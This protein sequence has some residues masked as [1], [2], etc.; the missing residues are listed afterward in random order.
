MKNPILF[1]FFSGSGF[2]DLGF[3]LNNFNV[4]FVNEYHKP[5]LEAYKY[6]RKKL[7]IA[8]PIFGFNDSDISELVYGNLKAYLNSKVTEAKKSKQPVGFIGGPPCP[9]FSVGGKNRGSS[10]ENGMLTKTY[11]D[12]II[13]NQPDFFIFE[14]VKGL[15]R[16]KAHRKFY[17]AMKDDLYNSGYLLADRLTNSIEYSVPQDRDRIILFGIKKCNTSV[18]NNDE[19]LSELSWNSYLKQDREKV[20]SSFPWPTTNSYKE[21]VATKMPEEISSLKELTIQHWF[22][23]ND[24]NNHPNSS[25]HF[26]P[27]AALKRFQSI[28]EGDVKKKSFKRLHRWRYSPTAA[29]GNNEVHIHPYKSRRLSAAEALAIQSLPK[30]FEL[31]PY[32][33]LSNMFKTIG[34][35][36]PYLLSEGIANMISDFLEKNYK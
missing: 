1:S 35:G 19:L 28:E 10:G 15:W 18:A 12:C 17:D 26:K 13:D 25:H 8:P 4:V 22:D 34:N 31:P 9:D 21:N 14:N 20:I 3:E 36:V 29:Y 23:K 16:T 33:S 5:F 7:N 2:L 30:N 24:V 27:R 11:I 6:S 32:M